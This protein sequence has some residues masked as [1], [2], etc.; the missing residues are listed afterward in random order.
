MGP[1]T[2]LGPLELLLVEQRVTKG[3]SAAAK[4]TSSASLPLLMEKHFSS[5]ERLLA[6][7]D[8][9]SESRRLRRKTSTVD[10]TPHFITIDS[11]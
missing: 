5:A 2:F 1:S 10:Q 7:A 4:G 11:Q 3:R 8:L 6:L 9:L